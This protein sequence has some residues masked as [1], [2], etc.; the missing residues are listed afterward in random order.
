MARV[1]VTGGAGFVGSTVVRALLERGD[2]VVVW[3]D[4]SRVGSRERL[5]AL[6]MLRFGARLSFRHVDVAVREQVDA[7]FVAGAPWD[8]VL[9]LAAQVAVTWS[10]QDPRH[11]FLVNALGAFHVI[12]AARRH[13]P[14]ARCVHVSSNKV[15]G[16]LADLAV[17]ED[18]PRFAFRD[19][20][21][22]VPAGRAL[23]PVTPYG[24]SKAAGESAFRDAAR[25]HG[26]DTVVLRCSCI[27]GPRQSQQED[28]GWVA[29]FA[30]AV[31]RGLPIRIFG[32]GRTTRDLL[33]VGDLVDLFLQ[34]LDGPPPPR[35]LTLAVGGGAAAARSLLE[36][37]ETLAQATGRR[38]EL[39]FHPERPADQRVFIT[40]TALARSVY[41]W[42]PR[43]GPDEGLRRLL[44]SP[45]E[46]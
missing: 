19:L 20:P 22:G 42:V 3:D 39:S 1:L 41:D 44:A 13:A 27:Y 12:D 37:V 36:V 21:D 9:H 43:V 34:V 17:R 31:L 40:D 23:D 45:V 2:D 11:D 7:A 24:V 29:W 32:D 28:Q 10:M 46:R 18:G 33:W 26:M 4:L 30:H 25:T 6:R 5:A 38:A 35:G 15:F 8:A 14:R 16:E